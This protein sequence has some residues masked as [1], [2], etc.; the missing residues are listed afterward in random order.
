MY[1]NYVGEKKRSEEK[2]WNGE[3]LE[4][5]DSRPSV[6]PCLLMNFSIT[7][8]NIIKNTEIQLTAYNILD[9]DHRDP[10]PDGKIKNDMPREARNFQVRLSYVF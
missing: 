7:V 8:Q 10:D 6:D 5:F 3:S 9:S 4:L 1:I 2:I